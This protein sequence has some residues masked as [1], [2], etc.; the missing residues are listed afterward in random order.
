MIKKPELT[1]LEKTALLQIARASIEAAVRN[2]NLPK[3]E[4]SSL[5]AALQEK[6]ASF[7]TLTIEGQLRGCI[8]T[9]EA[10]QPLAEDVR[11]HAIAAALEDYRFTPLRESELETVEIE[12]SRLTPTQT[13]FYQNPEDLPKL[14]QPFIDG[15]VLQDGQHGATFLPQVW[16]QLPEPE[17]FLTHLCLK[18]GVSGNLWREK[19]LQ[20]GIYSVEEFREIKKKDLTNF[21]SKS[22]G[23]SQTASS[24][25]KEKPSSSMESTKQIS[26]EEKTRPIPVEKRASAHSSQQFFSRIGKGVRS[27]ASSLKSGFIKW[28]ERR[29]E[30][31]QKS[32]TGKGKGCFP[33]AVIWTLLAILLVFIGFSAFLIVQYYTIAATLPSVED[34]KA[35]ASQFETTRIYDRNGNLIYEI[36]DPNAGFRT[37]I[38]LEDMSPYIVAATIATED[39]DFYNNPGFDFFGIVRALWQNYTSG[40]IVSGASTITQ[41]L[42][43]TLLLTAEERNQQT[44]QRKAKEIILAAEITRRYSKDEILE[45]YLNEIY[46]GNLTYG[47]QAAAETYFNTSA[48]QLNLAQ[49]SF[50]AGLPQ[51]PAVYDVFTN[52]Q[53]TFLRH[54]DVINLMYQLSAEEGCID[55]SNS[56]APV[57]V[58]MD[59]AVAAVL[60][61][62]GY[63]FQQKQ[64]NIPFPHWVSY[65][66][67][68]L[69]EQFDAQT[70]YRSGFNIYTTLDPDLQNYAQN[71][72]KEQVAKLSENNATDGALVAVQPQTGEILAMVGSADFNNEAIA[73]Q[74]NMAVSPRQ[75]G[76]SIKPLTYAAAFEKGWTPSTLIWDVESEFPPSGNENDTRDPYIPVNYDGKFHGPVLVRT[77]LGSSYNIPAVKTLQFVGI[78]DDPDTPEEEG[79]I[80]FAERMGI[81]TFTRDD[82]GLALTLGGGDVSLLELTSAFAIFANQGSRAEPFSISRIVDH[83]GNVV[84]EHETQTKQVISAEHA[85]LITDILADNNARTPAFGSNSILKLPFKVSV[86]TGTTND[87]RDNWTLGYTPDIAVGVWVGN[88]DYTPMQNT[89]GLTGAAPIWADVIQYAV[90]RYKGGTPSIVAQPSGITSEIVCAISGTKPSEKCP[91]EKSELFTNLQPPLSKENDLW[92]KV[93]LDTWTNKEASI[94]CTEFNDEKWTL[95]VTDK[96]GQEWITDTSAGKEWAENIGFT[97]QIIF[98]PDE[99]CSANDSQPTIEFVGLNNGSIVTENPLEIKV[100]I[101]VPSHFKNFK[102]LVGEG[103]NPG[104]WKVLIE[105]GKRTYSDATVI[106]TLDLY[107]MNNSTISLRLFVEN[108]MNGYAEKK[109]TLSFMLPTLTPMPTPTA[110]GT[111][112]ST[113]T[114]TPIPTPTEIPTLIP[115]ETPTPTPGAI[116]TETPSETPIP[117]PTG[118]TPEAPISPP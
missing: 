90:Q 44:V 9:L 49:A 2:E 113:P 37:Y 17:E 99:K 20:V 107:K 55:V 66:R 33:K 110:T 3:I 36:L 101:D 14:L 93:N 27:A 26:L 75:P 73:G 53:A 43:R 92:K 79:F 29:K 117:T 91:S 87:F 115:T 74:V 4:L 1:E 70:I 108:D 10:Y 45:L 5:P 30:R 28:K 104:N 15:V 84:Y 48:D 97:D 47:I 31:K 65:I 89:S 114:G 72:V 106:Y 82:Y 8:G 67:A 50:L 57:C 103:S 23:Y 62:E 39:K 105:D 16:E 88:A 102:L 77:A 71:A 81:T 7:V 18:M 78:Y 83:A 85:Y 32:G 38:S 58:T 116:P 64:V 34:L 80:K 98:S 21:A 95:N 41:Q 51:A 46:Y 35:N 68:L 54:Q 96:W 112:I 12:V 24:T 61:I 40:T 42:A 13:L 100:I 56:A 86:K 109:I 11:E 94:Y 52:T 60:A 118:M 22:T 69:E 76:S 6:G 59:E 111:P 63:P 25:E 19:A